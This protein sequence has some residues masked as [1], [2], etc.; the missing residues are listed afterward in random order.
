MREIKFRAWDAN[1]EAM[2][3]PFSLSK[4]DMYADAE[5]MQFTGL[6][7]RRGKEIY[8][9]DIVHHYRRDSDGDD[10]IRTVAVHFDA[11]SFRCGD[12][13]I[14]APIDLEVIGNIYE[15]P[16]LLK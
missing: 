3:I 16:E 9:G 11:G 12:W 4:A 5:V 13:Q 6:R 7:D 10:V 1:I 2:S 15:H 14:G 8:E